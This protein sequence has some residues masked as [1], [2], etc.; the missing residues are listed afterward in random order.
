MKIRH[1][2]ALCFTLLSAHLGICASS[3]CP[4]KNNSEINPDCPWITLTEEANNQNKP[5]SLI[6]RDTLWPMITQDAGKE[7]L[8]I[9]WGT[10]INYDE[11]TKQ[12]IISP[13][14]ADELSKAFNV[15][16]LWN[17]GDKLMHA[18]LQHTYGYML[19]NLMTSFGYKRAR[20]VRPDIE[21]GFGLSKGLL[22]PL[23]K[24][25]TLFTNVTYFL[26]QLAFKDE[27]QILENL[28]KN[29]SIL[30]IPSELINFDYSKLNMTRLEEKIQIGPRSVVI[31]TDIFPFINLPL[32]PT[33]NSSL[34]IYSVIDS[35][36][37]G[38]KLITAFPIAPSFEVALF[39]EK[40]LGENKKITSRYNAWIP[41][42]SN[43]TPPKMGVRKK[44]KNTRP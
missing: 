31:R 1:G 19:S 13:Y 21:N 35:K 7:I 42:V 18:G 25:G 28:E 34:L 5:L 36:E 39:Q 6:L 32:K 2:L 26:S 3:T 17:P 11:L 16:P 27:K 4:D 22:G 15:N 38:P 43:S 29:K 37:D 9:I 41:E 20:W 12:V 24:E 44:I 30:N 10:S 14:I 40:N 33:D 8:K 23:P